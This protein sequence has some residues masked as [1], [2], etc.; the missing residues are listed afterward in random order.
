M[1]DEET[2]KYI[3]YDSDVLSD[4][5]RPILWLDFNKEP[6]FKAENTCNLL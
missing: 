3:L 2:T 6:Y 1:L 4:T 5:R